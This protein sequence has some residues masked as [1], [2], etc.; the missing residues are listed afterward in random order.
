MDRDERKV[1]ALSFGEGDVV[2][3]DT[4]IRGEGLIE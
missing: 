2:G 1:S 3:F 4:R